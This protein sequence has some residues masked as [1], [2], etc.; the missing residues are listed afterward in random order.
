[1]LNLFDVKHNIMDN[2]RVSSIYHSLF[3]NNI[4]CYIQFVVIY[5]C[6]IITFVVIYHPLLKSFQGLINKHLNILYLDENV[7]EDFMPGPMVAFRSSRKLSSYL[8]RAKLYPLERM[9][10]SCK[11]NGK[12]CTVCLNVNETS[13][14]TSDR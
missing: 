3:N 9:T 13:T 12:R 11:C 4:C 7:K 5:N 8:V 14:F 1:M 10:G 6:S 2:T